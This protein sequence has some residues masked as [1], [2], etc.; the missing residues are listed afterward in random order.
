[1]RGIGEKFA[2]NPVTGTA[3]V[4]VPIFA[5]PGRQGFG[6][7]LSLSYD[8]GAG[9]GPFGFGWSLPLPSITRKT[10]KG[11]PQYADADESDVFIL[12]AAEDL[13]PVSVR[14]GDQWVHEELPPRSVYGNQYRVYRYR[15]RVEGIFTRV[16]RWVNESDPGDTLW[17]SIS[18]DNVTTWYG[19]T[20]ESRVA[21]PEDSSRVFAW[22]ICESYDDKGNL[23]IYQHKPED[24]HNV[25]V[26][27][28]HERNRTDSSRSANRYL[29][30]IFYG[31][32]TPYYPDLTAEQPVPAP[33]DWSF[34]LVFD[35]GEHDDKA[36]LPQEVRL[37]DCRDDSFS[38]Y[39]STFEIRTYRLCRRVLMFH[40][41]PDV[42]D[43]GLNCLVRSTEFMYTDTKPP[44][45]T[46]KPFYSFLRSV[47]QIG[48]RRNADGS[49]LAKGLPPLSCTYSEA[50]IDDNLLEID[51]ESLK[52]LP[53][54]LGDP[55]YH[56]VDLDGEGISGILTEQ[57]GA[58]F[59]KP[60]MSPI[61]APAQAENGPG[62]PPAQFGPTELI[63]HK[64]S[65]A[66]G[67]SQLVDLAGDGQLDLVE[68]DGQV[69]GFHERTFDESWA[70]FRTFKSL[71]VLDWNDPN[72]RFLDLTGNGR[73][74]LLI[75][76][77]NEFRWYPS[78]ST[79]GFGP[80]HVVPQALDEENGPKLIFAD[81]T[82]SIFLGDLSGDG[83][84]DIVRIRNGEV[85]YWPNRGYGR[86]GSKVTMDQ[87]PFFDTPD[88][89]DGR[90]LRLA[91]IDGSGTQDIVY[92][93]NGGVHLYF[94]QSGNGWG[95][96]YVLSQ[97][98]SINLE[99]RATVLDLLGNGTAC[100]VWSSP[101]SVDAQHPMR[102]V[103]LM[104]GQKPHLLVRIANNQGTET[105]VQYAASTKFYVADKI[106]GTPWLTRVPFPVHVI[107]KIE[108]FDFVSRNRFI[109]RYAYHHGFYDATEREFHGFG[110]VEQWD[111]E[112]LSTVSG[113][114]SYAGATNLDA[115]SSIAPVLT[116]TWFHTGAYFGAAQ[117]SRHLEQEYY[118]EGGSDNQG[119][120]SPG[121]QGDV[122]VLDSTVL[123]VSIRLQD[124]SRVPYSLSSDEAREACRALRGSILRQ[125]TYALDDSDA[126]NRP[127]NVSESNYTI[128][129]FQPQGPNRHAVFF[130]H[131]RETVDFQYER[132]LFKVAGQ[133][134][135]AAGTLPPGVRELADP[136]VS[137]A[138][139]LK[140]DP[141]GNELQGVAICYGRR[142]LDPNLTAADQDRQ[143]S[144]LVTF[145]EHMY[146]NA[147][148]LDDKYR[149][150]LVAETRSYQLVQMEPDRQAADVTNLFRF[151]EI[152]IK[153]AAASD[154]QHDIPYEDVDGTGANVGE[155]YRRLIGRLR[156]QYRPDDMGLAA[157]DSRTLL[158]VGTIE[159]LALPGC[160][161]K[162]AFT[163]GLLVRVYQDGQGPLLSNPATTLS[164][165]AADGGGYVDVDG[166]GQW[167]MTSGRTFY[168]PVA[169][170]AAQELQ[171]ARQHFFLAR[172]YEDAFGSE[173][174]VS[175]DEPRD[176][177]LI[178]TVDAMG[179]TVTAEN[180][181]RVLEP[182]LLTDPNGNRTAVSFDAL[183]LVAGTAIMGKT[184]ENLGDSLAGF[185]ADLTQQ[186]IDDFFA[187]ATLY[188][189]GLTALGSATTRIIYDLNRFAYTQASNPTDPSSWEPV[190]AATIARE[191]HSSNL[192]PGEQPK[193]Q[194]SVS[195]SDGFGREI[196]KKIQAEPGPVIPG[197]PPVDPRWVGTGW[198]IFNNKGK[199]VRRYEPFFSQLPS[200]GHHFEFGVTVGVSPILCY[201]G[202]GRVV[203]TIH[204]NHTYEKVVFEPWSQQG[205]DANDDVLTDPLMDVTVVDFFRRLPTADYLPSWYTA[206]AG[207]AL[208]PEEQDAAQKA[209]AHADTP[210]I[211]VLDPLGR[212]FLTV[213]DNGASAK[214]ASRVDL[215]IQNNQ[216]AVRDAIVQAGDNQGRLVM[217]YDYSLLGD[218][219]HHAGMDC[220]ERWVLND[221][222]GKPIRSW[223]S[224]SYSFRT[225][226]DPLRRP[227]KSFV[228]GG[229]AGDADS[230]VFPNDCLF[231]Q[232]IYGDTSDTGL[233]DAQR[234][235]ANLRGKLYERRDEAGI[236]RADLYDFKGNLSHSI[237]QFVSD[238]TTTPD[239]SHMPPLDPDTFTVATSFDAINRPVA[240]TTPDGSVYRPG[241]NMANLLQIVDVN[242]RGSQLKGQP[243]WTGFVSD[244][245]YNAK[246]QRTR[247]VYANNATAVYEYDDATFRLSHLKTTRPAG[248]NGMASKIFD[249]P[250]TVQDLSY[251]YDPVGNITFIGDAALK[252]VFYN[253]QQ[254]QPVSRYTYDPLYRLTEATGRE[255]VGQSAF[256]FVPPDAN[257]RDFP[258]VGASQLNDPQA[259]RNYTEQYAY[260]PVGNF[261]QMVH[262]ATNGNWTRVYSYSENS[263]TESLKTS[264]RLSRT[265]LQPNS[266]QP[267]VD[268]Y[269]Y[270]NDGNIITMTHLPHIR[271]SFRE[272]LRATSQQV[273]TVATPEI[274]YYV[275]DS[276]GERVRRVTET[277]AGVRKNERLYF[278]AYEVYREY[279]SGLKREAVGV[280]DG[281]RRVAVVETTTPA[282]AGPSSAFRY[283]LDNHL[284]SACVELDENAGLISHEEYGPYGSSSYQAGRTS[285]EVSL[286]RYRYCGK[287]R[288]M[289]SGLYYHGARYYAPWIARWISPD[290]GL[291]VDGTN[292]YQYARQNPVRY[293]DPAG[294][295]SLPPVEP[296]R[297]GMIIGDYPGLSAR[298]KAAVQG[299]L[300]PRYHGGSFAANITRY[301]QELQK[302]PVGTNTTPGSA[303]YIARQLFGRANAAFRKL[304]DLPQGSQVHHA[305]EGESLAENPGAALD[306]SHLEVTGGQATVPST[307]HYRA[308][309]A[310]RLKVK[311]VKNPGVEATSKMEAAR[312]ADVETP[313]KASAPAVEPPTAAAPKP[314]PEAVTPQA[315]AKLSPVAPDVAPPAA[316]TVMSRV[317]A[318]VDALTPAAARTLNAAAIAYMAYD[319]S[320]K[321]A[322]TTR[323]KGAAMGAAQFAKTSAKHATAILWFAAGAAVALAIASGGA[324]TPLAAA[325]IG[326]LVTTVGVTATHQ[327]I[328]DLTPDLK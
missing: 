137:H 266:G 85:C 121:Q 308:H 88:R 204:P 293:V 155:P 287:E 189:L 51:P 269:T 140:V 13:V 230:E 158:A 209:S 53:A 195:Y 87:S 267:I 167:W 41:F 231:E 12:A 63:A 99:Y 141:Y 285:A 184:T 200:R 39:R 122:M 22:L 281:T 145:S 30:H 261:S 7:Q 257:Y 91:D 71:P 52:N 292:L 3:S 240:I 280:L 193:L 37:W 1:M 116:K 321:T 294:T 48:Y 251:T 18:N 133:T 228:R 177:L 60:N 171:Q 29:K 252:S 84:T 181:Y 254:V 80:G 298:W 160:V 315:V 31:N 275:Y 232:A 10:D 54:G 178:G 245:D 136:R 273:T 169:G 226:H 95:A 4:N 6:P 157:G 225:E 172:R 210:R 113:S 142:Y 16:E 295:E 114:G 117:V 213:V 296:I 68:F 93:A 238:Y 289:E 299:V 134:L 132:R 258:F 223:T 76:G 180:D 215:D 286:K 274:T 101:M 235:A 19:K 143:R 272:L 82:Q 62:S 317:G 78:L 108:R 237:R 243:V 312:A 328:D 146:T 165:V 303:R 207:G 38:S 311:G 49:Y 79:E 306:A 278:G 75:S 188:D 128:E 170:T 119:V 35:Y 307:T 302:L 92:F 316:E 256:Q 50:R 253:N 2:A 43:I 129:M 46:T 150:P 168:L 248:L 249:D 322:Q 183:G 179:N 326:A 220:G 276:R 111:S 268:A 196:Q 127:Y 89:F 28:M 14:K 279:Q 36:P 56:W 149:S 131:P 208:G 61:G 219:I 211:A 26:S 233:T 244:I 15:P 109:T 212:T 282:N 64:P 327:A 320:N 270:D 304:V 203:A 325:A 236:V 33:T 259:I 32:R 290:P 173:T 104:G 110:R 40:H 86:F 147:V 239:W 69:P 241:Y 216:R 242:L 72:L 135:V 187:A 234:Q 314:P 8:S 176:L 123:P 153:V 161:Y 250:G 300:E 11:L 21:D 65:L 120:A 217:R 98:P 186:Q 23:V 112:Q 126:M 66:L 318:T 102:Y 192:R 255:G 77:E 73:A 174:S 115:S 118:R 224:R 154:G 283:Q 277:G 163:P 103:D 246:G 291:I 301:Q 227:V 265:T 152:Q 164:S 190:F 24:S 130:M 206:R 107:E 151:E 106:G 247:V 194:I 124:G 70:P 148:L 197:G 202:L 144:T 175:Y 201:D 229:N 59:Y 17:R 94:N 58:W 199:P 221:V 100:L 96:P 5:S 81:N 309:E 323:E 262:S 271:W 97:F 83:L 218:C 138:I 182:D 319:I 57:A 67:N 159:S 284:G 288:D 198:T 42:L 74:D 34:E 44:L 47:T 55:S 27:K 222:S 139:T 310:V 162:L 125:E 313:P 90:R 305:L 264:N 205:W 297:E 324:A 45:D 20:T 185:D 260:D 105:R 25:D 166:D 9:N 263:L 214:Y 191:T 156:T